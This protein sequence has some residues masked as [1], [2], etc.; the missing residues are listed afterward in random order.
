MG[1]AAECVFILTL[2]HEFQICFCF[3][4]VQ[5]FAGSPGKAGPPGPP[6]SPGQAVRFYDTVKITGWAL[7]YHKFCFSSDREKEWRIW[8][9][10]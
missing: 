3:Q 5:G 7:Q 8:R 10:V 4:G 2:Q 9:C 6:G 1:A